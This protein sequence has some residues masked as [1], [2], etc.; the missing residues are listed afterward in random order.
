MK[1]L[2]I[3]LSLFTAPT[4]ALACAEHEKSAK[5]P[6][7][8][9]GLDALAALTTTSTG[10]V[11]I[12]VNKAERYALGHIPGA[13]HMLVLDGKLTGAALPVE[14]TT[15][16]VFYC[17]N[18]QCGACH[19]GAEAAVALGYLNVSVYTGGIMGWQKA[20][21]PVEA[22]SGTAMPVAAPPVKGEG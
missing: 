19:S 6:Y 15:S 9:V 8:E 12:D 17:Y 4:L 11:I 22:T 5:K 18:E 13:V 21:K 10:A 2:L 3:A 1:T 20:G 14:K 16:L 7:G